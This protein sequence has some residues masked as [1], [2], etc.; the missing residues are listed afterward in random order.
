MTRFLPLLVLAAVATAGCTS[1]PFG[2][3]AKSVATQRPTG[4]WQ[5]TQIQFQ[6]YHT[7]LFREK[8]TGK[9]LDPVAAQTESPDQVT[10]EAADFEELSY[11][12]GRLRYASYGYENDVQPYVVERDLAESDFEALD[13]AI[14]DDK[15]FAA[16][17]VN[18]D[19]VKK[20]PLFYLSYAQNGLGW[21]ASFSPT[22]NRLA[23]TGPILN[24][25]LQQLGSGTGLAAGTTQV[26]YY[27]SAV[28]GTMTI[29]VS[30]ESLDGS[31]EL[32]DHPW[33][34]A[35]AAYNTGAGYQTGTLAKDGDSF[36]F[37]QPAAGS[38]GPY[39]LLGLKLAKGDGTTRETLIPVRGR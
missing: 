32:A 17:H 21:Y 38:N 26:V 27:T 1:L 6:D 9:V 3:A 37:A 5:K 29:A 28:N 24:G 18:V 4:M 14:Y 30:D 12:A 11:N 2:A 7:A 13:Q 34:F 19:A 16:P 31:N 35:S 23:K 22:M 8:A 25:Y 36:T 39:V 33:H 10:L 15:F 20:F